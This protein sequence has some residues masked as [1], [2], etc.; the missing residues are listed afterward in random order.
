VL[1]A[2]RIGADRV[3]LVIEYT[4]GAGE[5]VDGTVTVRTDD[6]RQPE[7]RVPIRGISG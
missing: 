7:I 3:E 1:P 4:G 5:D 6:P 2:K